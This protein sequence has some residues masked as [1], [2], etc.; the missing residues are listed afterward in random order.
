MKIKLIKNLIHNDK[1][2]NDLV[3]NSTD[4]K[5]KVI[6][7]VNFCNKNVE[8]EK[9]TINNTSFLGC[10]FKQDEAIKL[11]ERGA[12]VYP[13]FKNLPY[14]PYRG[15][16]YTWQELMEGYDAA[17]DNSIDIN[18]YK[19]FIKNKY[20][21]SVSEALAQRLHDHSIDDGLRRI[22]E[23]DK[24]GMTKKKVVG[25]MGGHSTRRGSQFYVE[26]AIAAQ[27]A[28]QKGYYV[29]T[30]GGP[31]IMEAANLGAYMAHYTKDDLLKAIDIL[32]SLHFHNIEE[33]DY[34]AENF[35]Q[36]SLEVL[37][38][39][40]NGSE[41]LA[42]PTWFYGHEPSNLFAKHIAK[43]FSNSIREDILL[44]ISLYG[45]VFAP[46]SAG[47]TQEIFQE[48]AQ[49]H[50][51]TSGYY[52]PMVFLGKKRYVEDTSIYSVVH[53]LAQGRVYKDLLFLTDSAESSIDFIENNP[54]IRV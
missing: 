36:R 47:T 54:P 42:I 28:T 7:D 50:Y 51:G 24:D 38:K 52:S 41:S 30:G 2:W 46:G 18:I 48:A 9:F 1:E 14:N 15:S 11:I 29:V 5:N 43:Y 6:Q 13:K 17:E 44:T 31:G 10:T 34:L 39:Y 27:L 35:M 45:L 25:F 32:K 37:D 12:F 23:Y 20:N 49:N 21:P 22:L 19:H 8:W 53:Q 4:L 33:P 3:N 16:L 40:P 26:T